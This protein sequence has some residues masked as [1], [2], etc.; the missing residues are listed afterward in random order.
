[1]T[2]VRPGVARTV[3]IGS[4]LVVSL[5]WANSRIFMM[6]RH[7]PGARPVVLA[8]YYYYHA[9]AVALER[10]RIGQYDEV[11]L[12]RYF[13]KN[14]LLARYDKL[15]PEVPERW[16]NY[17]ALDVGY[18]FIVEAARL[19]FPALPD[20][21]ARALALQLVIDALL[22][23]FLVWLFGR[24]RWW[25]G[26]LAGLLYSVNA[27]CCSLAT[28]PFYYYWDVPLA[29]VVIGAVLSAYRDA[30]HARSW[31]LVAASALG[32]GV[33]MRGSWWPLSAFVFALVAVQAPLRRA[34]VVPLY[35]FAVLA[36][37]QIVRSSIARSAPALSTRAA[38]HV[39]MVGLGYLPNPYGLDARDESVFQLTHDRF[40]VE[41]RADDYFAHDQAAKRLFLDIAQKDPR[42]VLRSFLLRLTDSVVG[43]DRTGVLSYWRVNNVAYRL[44]AL[45]GLVAMFAAGGELRLLAVMGAGIYAIYMMLTCAFYFV[46]PLYDNVPEVALLVWVV[47]GIQ[48]AMTLKR[49]RLR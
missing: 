43:A 11:R 29:F 1:M 15:P 9:M 47:G 27:A 35:V 25:L 20:S 39:A 28:I 16:V 10:G 34:M 45:A 23:A 33:W 38:W 24:W 2:A 26:L 12:T 49:G 40:G 18:L 6:R 42:F 7:Q 22:V 21:V 19:A 48:S 13:A 17:Y 46:A 30:V 14:D 37:P 8:G 4:L 3:W 5:V 36:V 32:I 44:I 41:F 31:L